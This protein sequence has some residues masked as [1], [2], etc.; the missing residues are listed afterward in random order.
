[1]LARRGEQKI[2][3]GRIDE[4]VALTSA[5]GAMVERAP[6]ATRAFVLTKKATALS[7]SGDV[8]ATEQALG[9]AR[10]AFARTTD[11]P[12]PSWMSSYGWGHLLHDEALCQRNLGRGGEA[13][14]AAEL[15]LGVEERVRFERPR[16]FTLGVLAIGH[17]QAGNVEQACATGQD[18]LALAA[19]LHSARVRGRV[20][21]LVNVLDG[22]REHPAVRDLRGAAVPALAGGV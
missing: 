1:M 20:A 11:R 21:E 18:L 22:H 4:A 8:G 17:A 9:E 6:S 15:A 19:R 14:R 10:D 7:R 2:Q 16:A 13:V 12:E 3:D 5:A